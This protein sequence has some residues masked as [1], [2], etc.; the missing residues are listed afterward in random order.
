MKHT[1]KV[2][3]HVSYNT[4]LAVS[5][6]KGKY[7]VCIVIQPILNCSY[8][9]A[10]PSLVVA[11]IKCTI[12]KYLKRPIADLLLQLDGKW[13]NDQKV[14][15]NGTGEEVWGVVKQI[16]CFYFLFS[17]TWAYYEPPHNTP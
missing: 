3:A 1:G 9:K 12:V 17:Y 6:S 8:E 5:Y 7:T 13:N 10:H 15:E 2:K 4:A 14:K 16:I 11:L